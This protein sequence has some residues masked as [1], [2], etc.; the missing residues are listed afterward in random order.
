[1][2]R[3][4]N[5]TKTN[6]VI[7]TKEPIKTK[8][9]IKTKT[10]KRETPKRKERR[11]QTKRERNKNKRKENQQEI[12]QE[13]QVTYLKK[14]KNQN[15]NQLIYRHYYGLR[16]FYYL[17]RMSIKATLKFQ[18]IYSNTNVFWN[19]VYRNFGSKPTF[20]G[21]IRKIF[22]EENGF[23]L[24][25]KE[26]SSMKMV[27]QN[28]H[29]NL[30]PKEGKQRYGLE[31]DEVHLYSRHL[32][33]LIDS[34][35]FFPVFLQ[36][37][38]SKKVIIFSSLSTEERR[39]IKIIQNLK[40][41][42][43]SVSL[44]E[45]IVLYNNHQL[46]E[47]LYDL[48]NQNYIQEGE[49]LFARISFG[50]I[51]QNI[52]VNQN[53]RVVVITDRTRAYEIESPA[54]LNRFEKQLVLPQDFISSNDIVQF[55]NEQFTTLKKIQSITNQKIAKEDLIVN[56]H[57]DLLPS[58]GIKLQNKLT[59][60]NDIEKKKLLRLEGKK[61]WLRI[62]KT[63][64]MIE[65]FDLI[66]SGTLD[67]PD[68]IFLK[69]LWIAYQKLYHYNF[70][71][72]FIREISQKD[73]KNSVVL[74]YSS[75]TTSKLKLPE[76]YK[77]ASFDISNYETDSEMKKDMKKKFYKQID[78]EMFVFAIHLSLSERSS[79]ELFYQTKYM[80]ETFI[81]DYFTS[82]GRAVELQDKEENERKNYSMKNHKCYV[83][84]V[85][86]LA[87]NQ[88]INPFSYCFEDNWELYY[89]DE[90]EQKFH[91]DLTQIKKKNLK[92]RDI[93]I[94]FK[95]KFEDFIRE[96]LPVAIS[97]FKDPLNPHYQKEFDQ[98]Y[99]LLENE[100]IRELLFK[101]LESMI[102]EG[103]KNELPLYD[104]NLKKIFSQHRGGI[105]IA[106]YC[107][108]IFTSKITRILSLLIN[109][110][111][112]NGNLRLTKEKGVIHD[113]WFAIFQEYKVPCYDIFIKDQFKDAH[114]P[115]SFFIYSLLNDVGIISEQQKFLNEIINTP[116]SQIKQFNELNENENENLEKN[117]C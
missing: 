99:Y 5:L 10:P 40:Q 87:S 106:T 68:H 89:L 94:D 35:A 73:I 26:F 18:K 69:N 113:I 44:G 88:D 65:I 110:L 41:V 98:V 42:E 70:S 72:L 3:K 78:N 9:L 49:S 83:V 8:E 67:P 16:D 34:L 37:I 7:K 82:S 50:H 116:F 1:M 56:Y 54:I 107:F 100:E 63:E 61:F 102:I 27:Q 19:E 15:Q 4:N 33:V 28:I 91:F 2:Q 86:H 47:P 105:S 109:N 79:L 36:Q 104:W 92:L 38:K 30:L 96:I 17:L 81:A 52:C 93:F 59:N 85:L 23:P 24:P 6:Q 14:Q 29:G 76:E 46:F 39:S 80:V 22:S 75:I 71:E 103:N 51:T 53:F 32:M 13:N 31:K 48:L 11:S 55:V 108:D 20:L 97:Q 115:F 62:C 101:N 57:F 95:P 111:N 45:T 66:A 60:L 43:K 12:I 117:Y 21:E 77:V 114:F 74:T 58:L 25:S 84:F 64:K 90:L 112:R